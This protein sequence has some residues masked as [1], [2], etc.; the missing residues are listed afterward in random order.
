MKNTFFQGNTDHFKNEIATGYS[1]IEATSPQPVENFGKNKTN[2]GIYSNVI[3]L[4][5]FIEMLMNSG[6]HHGKEIINPSVIKNLE[7]PNIKM[8]ISQV[9]SKGAE[10]LENLYYGYGLNIDLDFFGKKMINHGGSVFIYTSYFGYLPENGTYF[11]AFC[12]TSAYPLGNIG[13]YAMSIMNRHSPNELNFIKNESIIAKLSGTY[14]SYR[15]S[16][17]VEVSQ[18]GSYLHL[19]PNYSSETIHLVP[20]QLGETKS[21]YFTL[22]GFTK[23]YAVFSKDESGNMELNYSG[24]RLKKINPKG[25]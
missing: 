8:D 21:V 4:S 25:Q 22:Q 2:G 17:S 11:I 6:D 15:E 9:G 23:I 1:V 10:K 14:A 13:K 3:D 18:K 20:E 24:Q 16:I 5:I 19:R 7:N 12:N